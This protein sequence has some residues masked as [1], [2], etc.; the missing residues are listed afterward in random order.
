MEAD[1]ALGEDR[2]LL[3]NGAHSQRHL[4]TDGVHGIAGSELF[5]DIFERS[6]VFV[7]PDFAD[8]EAPVL[9]FA[10]VPTDENEL[11]HRGRVTC[12]L[13]LMIWTCLKA[14]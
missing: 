6:E 14:K 10:G 2:L 12:S 9:S 8:D 13:H 7:G 4:F 3:G 1:N 5:D 11:L